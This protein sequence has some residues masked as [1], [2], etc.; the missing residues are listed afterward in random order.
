MSQFFR[1]RYALS[2]AALLFHQLLISIIFKGS[3]YLQAM[4]RITIIL[5]FFSLIYSTR[6]QAQET[7]IDENA[8]GYYSQILGYNVQNI[9]NYQVFNLIDSWLNTPYKYGGKDE[10]GIDCSGFVN[11]IIR[12]FTGANLG[13]NSYD[14]YHKLPHV[15]FSNLKAGDLVFFRTRGKR[16]S[17]VGMYLGQ[18]KFVHSSTSNGVIVSD[19]NQAYYKKRFVKGGRLNLNSAGSTANH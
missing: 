1:S 8:K 17:H 10:N 15:N 13:C 6:A 4:K 9:F 14:M 11:T 12:T 7:V 16:V 3:L 18:D 19:I 2:V 5:L